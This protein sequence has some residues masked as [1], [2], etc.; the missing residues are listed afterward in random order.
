MRLLQWN[1][2]NRP[3]DD[4]WIDDKMPKLISTILKQTPDAITLQE[5]PVNA[6]DYLDSHLR[7]RGYA[8]LAGKPTQDRGDVAIIAWNIERLKC[9]DASTYGMHGIDAVTGCL[10]PTWDKRKYDGK[11][12]FSL[13]S[14]HG[15]WGALKQEERLT[16]L[17]KLDAVI[18]DLDADGGFLCGDFNATRGE[19]G[20][21]WLMGEAIADDGS[22]FVPDSDGRHSMARKTT[23]WNEAQD[24]AVALGRQGS[25]LPTTL[26]AGVAEE[27]AAPHGIDV[28]YMPRRRIDFMFSRGWI[29]GKPYGWTGDV[30]VEDRPE[31]SDHSLIVAET[32][33]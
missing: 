14:Y 10:I 26:N 22:T 30:R 21:R 4:L 15:C 8:M 28:K 31:L 13:T 12:S 20:I 29:Y 17:R 32:I 19:D 25:Q 1:V 23:Y 18:G 2:L 33:D 24:V 16:E 27:T 9:V 6:L 7:Q 5:V 3:V 11:P